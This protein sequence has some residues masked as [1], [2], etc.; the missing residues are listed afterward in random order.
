MIYF[1]A[2]FFV[3]I[4]HFLFA[5]WA[6]RQ[7]LFRPVVSSIQHEKAVNTRF[8]NVITVERELLEKA[9]KEQSRQWSWYQQQFKKR[10]PE[11]V[12][13]TAL[14]VRSFKRIEPPQISSDDKKRD[15]AL[16]TDLVV[17][18]LSHD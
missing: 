9:Q 13:H 5:W 10:I 17:S 8:K 2:T 3:Q 6:L 16:L 14:S 12:I 18:R 7:F 4:F 15:C 11:S 1:N